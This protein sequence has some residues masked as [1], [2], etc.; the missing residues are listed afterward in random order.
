MNQPNSITRANDTWTSQ[1]PFMSAK[2]YAFG[3]I[4][5]DCLPNGRYPGGAPFNVAIHLSQLVSSALI[6][7][8]GQDALGDEILQVAKDKG[9]DTTF[10]TRARIGLPTGTVSV[11]IDPLGNA[12]YEIIQPVAWDEICVPDELLTALAQ[13]SA[14]VFGTLACRSPYNR[15]QLERLLAVEG[16]MKFFDVN[17]RPPFA[18]PALAIELA[19][20][21][22]VIKLN[23]EEAGLLATW[24]QTGKA[25]GDPPSTV[26]A[27]SQACATIAAATGVSRIC[28]TRAAHGAALWDAGAM[29]CAPSPQVTV[30]DTVGAGDAFMAALMLGLIGGTPIPELLEHAC[31]IGAYVA[32]CDGATPPLPRGLIETIKPQAF[33]SAPPA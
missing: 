11:Q 18:D 12:T 5:W 15:S 21:A 27:L 25:I 23:D 26:T 33:R 2:Y 1:P 19:K 6:S 29:V 30:R 4:L 28:V 16:P 10:V 8:V 31:Q 14:L 17:L 7:T 3:E 13:A 20:R 24:L 9:V 32:S 22:D